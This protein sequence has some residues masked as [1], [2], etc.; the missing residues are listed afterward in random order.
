[1]KYKEIK[2]GEKLKPYVKCYFLFESE[3][4]TEI[5][6]I[7]FPSGYMEIMFNL[8]DGLW[9]SSNNGVFYTTPPM[10]LWG[11][12]TRPLAI[13]ANGKNVML[14]IRFFTHTAAYFLKEDIW[15]L[16][17][18]VCDLGYLLGGPAKILHAKLLET[19]DL[20][21]RISMLENFLIG[22]LVV[23]ERKADK[24]DMVGRIM[25]DM[26]KDAFASPVEAVASHYRISP[27]YLQKLFLQ[28]AGV[29][30]KLYAKINR[31]QN[32]LRLINKRETSLT[33]VAYNCGY[34]DQ[35]HFIREFKSFTGMTPS[36][37]SPDLY[38]VTQVFTQ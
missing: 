21:A 22:R 26:K 16:N 28:H 3:A 33:S 31:F 11:Q 20:H 24:I 10:E 23:N 37:Y 27:R 4:T 6:D 5:E 36:A 12:V 38:P 9:K 15:E 13:R 30:P 18:Q 34:F 2:P 29:A 19:G 35:S 7:V 17:N 1:M 8:G 14:G 32:S 25:G